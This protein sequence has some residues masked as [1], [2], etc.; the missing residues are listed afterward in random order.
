MTL[1]VIN[2]RCEMVVQRKP[3]QLKRFAM[4]L[5]WMPVK[6]RIFIKIRELNAQVL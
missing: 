1:Q 5:G 2:A 6:L 4:A 3:G